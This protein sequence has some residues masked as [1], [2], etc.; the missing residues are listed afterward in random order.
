MILYFTDFIEICLKRASLRH[1][2]GGHLVE[3]T[4]VKEMYED[5][6]SLLKSNIELFSTISFLDVSEDFIIQVTSNYTPNWI[7]NNDLA[8]YLTS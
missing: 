4:I 7:K 5:T 2:Y 3:S 1:K 6:I 8:Q